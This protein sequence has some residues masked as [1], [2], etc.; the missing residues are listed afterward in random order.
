MFYDVLS[1]LNLI[2]LDFYTIYHYFNLIKQWS[3]YDKF[4]RYDENQNQIDY[5]GDEI[6]IKNGEFRKAEKKV[7][8]L[9]PYPPPLL[10]PYS[11]MVIGTLLLFF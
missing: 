3:I 6:K 8:P 4:V 7:S 1:Y 11:L 9:R 5:L 10:T 2:V